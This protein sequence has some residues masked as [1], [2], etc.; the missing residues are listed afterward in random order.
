MIGAED[1]LEASLL[2]GETIL[3]QAEGGPKFGG[4]GGR[5]EASSV[6]LMSILFLMN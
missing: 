1:I 5:R 6:W 3:A 2:L 4:P